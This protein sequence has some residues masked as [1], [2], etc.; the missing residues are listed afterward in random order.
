MGG[1]RLVGGDEDTDDN[2]A[3]E[4]A[5]LAG[6]GESARPNTDSNPFPQGVSLRLVLL[7]L[8]FL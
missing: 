8:M 4:A 6:T 5:A 2:L 1:A 7:Q 3:T